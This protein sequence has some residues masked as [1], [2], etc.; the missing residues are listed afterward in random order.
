MF[1]NDLPMVVI[2]E[3]QQKVEM[4]C[5][6]NDDSREVQKRIRTAEKKK[7]NA[8]GE[9]GGHMIIFQPKTRK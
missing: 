4:R 5:G 8:K 6:G 2:S 7:N 9:V 1:A 3:H